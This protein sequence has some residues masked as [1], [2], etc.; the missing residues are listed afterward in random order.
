MAST[1]YDQLTQR[2]AAH[3]QKLKSQ[4]IFYQRIFSGQLTV[5]E[6]VLFIKNVSYL[7][8][9]TPVHLNMAQDAAEKRGLK[10]L[11]AY[12]K[13]KKKEEAG[14]D[15]WG[16]NDIQGIAASFP[17][18][19][20]NLPVL[21]EMKTYVAANEDLIK[22]DPYLYFVYILFAEYYTV[23][24]APESL[25]AIEKHCKVPKDLVSI[26]SNHAELDKHHVEEWAEEAREVGID[27]QRSR[28]YLEALEQIFKRYDAFCQALS[29]SHAKAA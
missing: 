27:P 18:S 5:D 3:F 8:S 21:P 22:K 23:I 28:E 16:E 15:Q 9:Y 26:I 14:H 17:V 11:A 6:L 20:K 29:R 2:I 19:I 13:A 10:H 4:N 1:L 24:A 25:S 7:T 12:F